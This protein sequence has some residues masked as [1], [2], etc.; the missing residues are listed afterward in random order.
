MAAQTRVLD[1]PVTVTKLNQ[2]TTAVLRQVK[3]G[4]VLPITERG[5]VIAFL[6]P[7]PP[8]VTGNPQIDE[9]IANGRLVPAVVPGTILDLLP[10]PPDDGFSL[11]DAI[12]AEREREAGNP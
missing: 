6:T 4:H 11:A 1:D 12:A 10:T 7:P 9:W 3:A 8:T 5:K 2:Q